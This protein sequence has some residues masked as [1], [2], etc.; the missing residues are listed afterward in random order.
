MGTQNDVGGKG[1]SVEGYKGYAASSSSRYSSALEATRREA[2]VG[3]VA[4]LAFEG[5][6]DVVVLAF[7]LQYVCSKGIYHIY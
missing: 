6:N 2:R 7:Q 1:R 4:A 3:D 5:L